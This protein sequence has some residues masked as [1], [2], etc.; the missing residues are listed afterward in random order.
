M[1]CE[2]TFE[3]LDGDQRGAEKGEKDCDEQGF[4]VFEHGAVRRFAVRGFWNR[5]LCCFKRGCFCWTSFPS[6]GCEP[7]SRP[8]KAIFAAACSASSYFALRSARA[9]AAR[10]IL[11]L[12]MFSGARGRTR[13]AH[14]I[15]RRRV[16]A[17][18]TIPA[19]RTCDR[20]DPGLQPRHRGRCREECGART[21]ARRED[22]RRDKSRR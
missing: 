3:S 15:E 4:G 9:S 10:A 21:G 14:D 22:R 5:L 7:G 8:A 11:P 12:Q 2:G 17:A 1:D 18:A 20:S 6:T 13:C 16:R 19:E